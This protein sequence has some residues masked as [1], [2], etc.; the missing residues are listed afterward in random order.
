[1]QQ[2]QPQPQQQQATLQPAPPANTSGAGGY[3]VQLASYRDAGSARDGFQDMKRRPLLAQSSPGASFRPFLKR[4]TAR[5]YSPFII[6][7]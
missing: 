5:P 3:V 6:S 7:S 1:V 4:P 2:P